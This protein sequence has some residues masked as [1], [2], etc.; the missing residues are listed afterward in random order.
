M[1]VDP[2]CFVPPNMPVLSPGFPT[3]GDL[4]GLSPRMLLQ[5]STLSME[6]R[7]FRPASPFILPDALIVAPESFMAQRVAQ[8]IATSLLANS[9]TIV[10]GRR[11]QLLRNDASPLLSEIVGLRASGGNVTVVNLH[12]LV[13]FCAWDSSAPICNVEREDVLQ[14][15]L[16]F[17]VQLTALACDIDAQD[18]FVVMVLVCGDH[19]LSLRV[20]SAFQLSCAPTPAAHAMQPFVRG[21]HHAGDFVLTRQVVEVG[22]LPLRVARTRSQR[23]T[24]PLVDAVP[25]APGDTCR[26]EFV[27]IRS[28]RA[29]IH[30]GFM[31]AVHTTHLN[32]NMNTNA[33]F[34]SISTHAHGVAFL[35]CDWSVAVCGKQTAACRNAPPA[36]LPNLVGRRIAI[37]LVRPAGEVHV[38]WSDTTG[39][40]G[41]LVHRGMMAAG[42]DP[43]VVYHPAV[44]MTAEGNEIDIR[45]VDF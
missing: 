37:E 2:D 29:K 3:R 7:S 8:F 6:D 38:Y 40:A 12:D 42:L 28:S 14:R 18:G 1:S 44:S 39:G 30:I 35:C 17:V 22:G 10:D 25:V 11:E 5:G 13:G 16:S 45:R 9:I 41:P 26:L 19:R 27:V 32:F 4:G 43:S 24:S 20:E 34:N 33:Y 21:F 23:N 31:N 36:G 15:V